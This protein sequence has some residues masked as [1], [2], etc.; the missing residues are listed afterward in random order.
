MTA[1]QPDEIEVEDQL[2]RRIRKP[3]DLLRCVL[4]CIGIVAL[5]VAGVAASA[6]MS[7]VQTDIVGASRRLPHALLVVVPPLALFALLI[8]PVAMAVQLLVR[9]Q[10]RRLAEA[11][12]T[13]VLA[14]AVTAV[15][16]DL[17]TRPAAS[18]LYDAIIMARPGTSHAAALDPYLAGLVAYAT[19]VG[20]AG[21]P[22]WRN[23]L[24]AA[25]AVYVD[26]ARGSVAHLRADLADHGARQAARSAWPSG[27]SR[28]RR[29]SGPAPWRS[30]ARWP[31]SACR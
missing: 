8:L 28:A 15:A 21:R 31:P 6:T 18:R 14:A 27:T 13:G 4:S 17:L 22:Y 23:A 9:R 19:M 10:F 30:R 20:L 25:I 12:A 3:V 16:S 24:W 26:R 1:S 11:V 7:G 29:R 2:E 5:A